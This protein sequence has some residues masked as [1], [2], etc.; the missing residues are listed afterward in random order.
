VLL[1]GDAVVR[2]LD[3]LSA[4][5]GLAA[6]AD[7]WYVAERSH[8]RVTW[9]SEDGGRRETVATGLPLGMPQAGLR[10]GRRS[11]LLA[12]AGGSVRVGCDGD[13]G[14]RRLRRG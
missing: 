10:L 2:T 1:Q 12:E 9:H 8:G 11:A 4:P 3:G 6:T 14:I 13:G 7:G 5:E